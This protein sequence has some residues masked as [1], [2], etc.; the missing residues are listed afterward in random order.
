MW[1]TATF[2]LFVTFEIVFQNVKVK[3]QRIAMC[4]FIPQPVIQG[5][6]Q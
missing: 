6:F 2:L 3:R 4:I 1:N 5:Q